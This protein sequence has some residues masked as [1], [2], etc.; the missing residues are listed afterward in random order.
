MIPEVE[1]HK[2]YREDR[3]REEEIRKYG[4]VRNFPGEESMT[5]EERDRAYRNEAGM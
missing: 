1:A 5:K 4:F 2:E 3:E